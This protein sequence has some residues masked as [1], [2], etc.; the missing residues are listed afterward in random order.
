MDDARFDALVKSAAMGVSR[1]QILR[2]VVAAVGAVRWRPC[3]PARVRQ[4]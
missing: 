1:R 4:A 3:Q 2:G